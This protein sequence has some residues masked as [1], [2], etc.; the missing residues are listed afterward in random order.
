MTLSQSLH[1]TTNHHIFHQRW[2]ECS[3]IQCSG[4]VSKVWKVPW[5]SASLSLMSRR[6]SWLI[7]VWSKC[8]ETRCARPPHYSLILRRIDV[9]A[10]SLQLRTI[11]FPKSSFLSMPRA[12]LTL[13][14]LLVVK[15]V[16]TTLSLDCLSQGKK[17]SRKFAHTSSKPVY[18]PRLKLICTNKRTLQVQQEREEP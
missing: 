11:S 17:F 5:I 1:R 8:E 3:R 18:L 16:N 6:I 4:P 13:E 15:L 12:L 2:S 10:I 9:W 7:K 14:A